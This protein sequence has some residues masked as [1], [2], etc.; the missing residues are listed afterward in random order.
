MN[1]RKYHNEKESTYCICKDPDGDE[2]ERGLY[3][4]LKC[5]KQILTTADAPE[6]DSEDDIDRSDEHRER[7]DQRKQDAMNSAYERS[8][9]EHWRA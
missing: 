2:V 6:P 5:N 9:D 4:C 3:V 1:I 8:L 7:E